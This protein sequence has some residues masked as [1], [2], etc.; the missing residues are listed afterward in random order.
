MSFWLNPEAFEEDEL[1]C[2]LLYRGRYNATRLSSKAVEGVVNL[3]FS[4]SF[5]HPKPIPI[6]DALYMPT[7][8]T[9]CTN[10][11]DGRLYMLSTSLLSLIVF[12]TATVVFPSKHPVEYW[13]SAVPLAT[14]ALGH[15][16]FMDHE[17]APPKQTFLRLQAVIGNVAPAVWAVYD[18]RKCYQETEYDRFYDEPDQLEA[19]KSRAL[20]LRHSTAVYPSFCLLGLWGM[21]SVGRETRWSTCGRRYSEGNL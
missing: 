14:Q 21:D 2:G 3:L 12:A 20:H 16:H 8:G 19:R 4:T 18:W 1:R 15:S 11:P 5:F 9:P 7:C 6:R 13:N 17:L 10:S